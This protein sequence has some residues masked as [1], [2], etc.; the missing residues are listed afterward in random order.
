MLI[1]YSHMDGFVINKLFK[2]NNLNKIIKNFSKH[3]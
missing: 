2:N 1:L 3:Y